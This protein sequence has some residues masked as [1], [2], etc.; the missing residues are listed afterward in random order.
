LAGRKQH[1]QLYELAKLGAQARLQDLIH[2]AKLLIDLF[3][4]LRDSFDPDELPAKFLIKRGRDR[5]DAKALGKK[6]KKTRKKP[7]WTAEQREAVAA[8]M[9]KYWAKRKK[10]ESA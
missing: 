4:H 8:R 3:P 6:T 1:P 2:E 7:H 9:K 10:S 5:A